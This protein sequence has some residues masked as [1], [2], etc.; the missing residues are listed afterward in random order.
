M[1]RN[2]ALESRDLTRQQKFLAKKVTNSQVK[3]FDSYEKLV[4][5][6]PRREEKEIEQGAEISPVSLLEHEESR[7]SSI[8]IY[9]S[10]LPDYQRLFYEVEE[11]ERL[12]LRDL[13]N[14]SEK[15]PE[16]EEDEP[17]P[18]SI[19]SASAVSTKDLEECDTE[20]FSDQLD[21]NQESPVNDS[22]SIT[23]P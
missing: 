13:Q 19:L 23:F 7:F 16:T 4:S 14:Q 6:A 11:E 10:N 3:R 12:R 21:V 22:N 5:E 20:M 8:G 1:L 2:Q 9:A 17:R 15:V 18:V